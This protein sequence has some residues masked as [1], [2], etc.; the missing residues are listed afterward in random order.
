MKRHQL[1]KRTMKYLYTHRLLDKPIFMMLVEEGHLMQPDGEQYI[2]DLLKD[3]EVHE[4][5]Y[6]QSINQYLKDWSF[7]RLS[8][9]EQAIILLAW[10]ELSRKQD[11]KAVIIDEAIS[12][13]K[14]YADES[15]YQYINAV[16][17]HHD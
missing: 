16:L 6:I 10:S 2:L 5:D 3:I 17:D 14:T 7:E 11:D 8:Y 1:R 12:L 13:A 9:V 4:E 15:A